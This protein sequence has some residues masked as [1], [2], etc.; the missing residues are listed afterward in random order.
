V[1]GS[2]TVTGKHGDTVEIPCNKGRV[3]EGLVKWKYVSLRFTSLIFW[4]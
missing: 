3:M 4:S 2:E 1:S